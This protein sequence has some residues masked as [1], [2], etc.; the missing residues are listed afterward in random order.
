ME[1]FRTFLESSTI[2]GLVY[3]STSSQRLVRLFWVLVV[4]LGFTG[5]GILIYQSFQDWSENPITTTL[6]TLPMTEITLPKVTVCPPKNTYT[7]LNHDLMKTEN[8]TLDIATRNQI[9][10]DAV[11]LIQNHSFH[12]YMT[13]FSVF[14]ENNRYSNWY[15]GYTQMRTRLPY[16]GQDLKQS[17]T[18][19]G[20]YYTAGDYKL[21]YFV[22]T[23][24]PS[25]FISTQYFGEKFN[26]DLIQGQIQWD[27]IIDIPAILQWNKNVS[28]SVELEKNIIK[29]FD[30]FMINSFDYSYKNNTIK[31]TLSPP[32]SLGD[33]WSFKLERKMTVDDINDLEMDFMPGFRLKWYYSEGQAEEDNHQKP[34]NA[35]FHR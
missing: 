30:R 20:N 31:D 13:N 33:H 3:I 23:N 7:N 2:H 27:F 35:L 16:W 12:E 10:S 28:L 8:V 34:T 22:K 19:D 29:S 21:K 26:A 32:G 14:R 5:A 18:L 11:G 4:G 25:G 24:A 17:N 15:K 1:G 6:E 9:A